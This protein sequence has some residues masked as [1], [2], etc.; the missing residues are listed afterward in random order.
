MS[1]DLVINLISGIFG[2]AIALIFRE[3]FTWKGQGRIEVIES[4]IY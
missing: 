3:L 4:M 1:E 2:A